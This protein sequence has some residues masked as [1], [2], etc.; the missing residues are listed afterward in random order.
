MRLHLALF[1]LPQVGA[2]LRAHL[3]HL[4]D[5]VANS[6]VD[7]ELMVQQVTDM[8]ADLASQKSQCAEWRDTPIG[9]E[10]RMA[11]QG[12][13]QVCLARGGRNRSQHVALE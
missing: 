4:E 12:K 3:R 8:A 11:A 10:T 1:V 6:E 5:A 7:R 9:L 2:E 13:E